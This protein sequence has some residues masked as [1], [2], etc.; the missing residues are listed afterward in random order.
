[1]L[2]DRLPFLRDLPRTVQEV[3]LYLLV[4]VAT[5]L[6]VALLRLILNLLIV[7][8][9]RRRAKATASTRD[10]LILDA[11]IPPLRLLLL[12]I[13]LFISI[14]LLGTNSSI[15]TLVTHIVRTLVIVGL[16]VL[17]YRL[18]NL[19][20]TTSTRL[21][22]L[23]G[24]QVEERLLPFFRVGVQLLLI[25]VTVVIIIQEW[26]YDVSGL[27]AGL[28][29]GG[30]AL[31]LAAQD[32]LANVFGFIAIVGDRP[33]DVGEYIVT[34]DVEGVVERVGLR[35]TRVRRL[36]QALISVPNNKLANSAILNWNKLEKRRVDYILNV[37]Y[38]ATSSDLRHLLTHLRDLL[39]TH[40]N[41]EPDSIVVYFIEFGNDGLKIL[42]RCYLTIPD[43]GQFTAEKEQIN[44]QVMDIVRD[45][46]LS[47]A[48]PSRSVYIEN[49][50]PGYDVR[51]ETP[52]DELMSPRQRAVIQNAQDDQ[53]AEALPPQPQPGSETDLPDKG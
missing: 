45:L 46:G 33:F 21:F 28:G 11:I 5:L 16:V 19:F 23:T 40:P 1:M 43:W 50:P 39:K 51:P 6:L 32:T 37:T 34:P 35:S 17:I 10:D 25:A 7:R 18:V 30:L 36:D 31:S 29:L 14:N 52:E 53:E 22:A 27:V 47:V 9:L 42:V 48:L 38:D 15:N 49:F 24:I 26:G 41:V 13:A 3:L 2:L 20:S 4:P 12:A 44:L 8:P